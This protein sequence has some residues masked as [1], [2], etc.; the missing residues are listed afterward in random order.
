[1]G[2]VEYKT[3]KGTLTIETPDEPGQTMRC[4]YT[5]EVS[6]DAA[7]AIVAE[8]SAIVNRHITEQLADGV[9]DPAG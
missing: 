3:D 9:I 1:M 4:W 2:K 7:K 8:Y 6:L 5:G